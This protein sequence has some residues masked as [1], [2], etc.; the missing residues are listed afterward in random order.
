MPGRGPDHDGPVGGPCAVGGGEADPLLLPVED[1]EGLGALCE[2]DGDGGD[3]ELPWPQ[4]RRTHPR[5][6]EGPEPQPS[7]VKPMAQGAS[8]RRSLVRERERFLLGSWPK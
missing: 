7:P 2:G 8:G 1:E 5:A 6:A 3:G 4:G